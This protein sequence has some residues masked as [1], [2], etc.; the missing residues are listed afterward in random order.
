MGENGQAVY[1]TRISPPTAPRKRVPDALSSIDTP[2]DR[3]GASETA[4]SNWITPSEM[5][6]V[7]RFLLGPERRV[8]SGTAIPIYREA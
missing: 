7:A 3:A 6:A 4:I 8:I 1:Y 2:A 5:A